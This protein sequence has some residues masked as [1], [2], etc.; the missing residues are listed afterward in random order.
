MAVLII[1][2]LSDL[3]LIPRVLAAAALKA[4]FTSIR[5]A[6]GARLL[7]TKIVKCFLAAVAMTSCPPGKG[8]TAAR[9]AGDTLAHFA[10]IFYTL[11]VTLFGKAFKLCAVLS[12]WCLRVKCQEWQDY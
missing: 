5:P 10:G 3:V 4:F 12:F 2:F 9:M 8:D 6:P 1:T 11:E 7:R